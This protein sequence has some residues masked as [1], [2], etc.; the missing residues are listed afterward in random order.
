MEESERLFKE[1]FEV[2]QQDLIELFEAVDLHKEEDSREGLDDFGIE[3]E[4]KEPL[5]PGASSD[6]EENEN[7]NNLL[8]DF[9]IEKQ[10][11]EE[12]KHRAPVQSSS[13]NVYDIR[14]GSV[15]YGLPCI[16]QTRRTLDISL[17]NKQIQ[18]INEKLCRVM[19]H[20]SDYVKLE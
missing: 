9:A 10:A 17:R 5:A 2:N 4:L 13:V 7:L 19:R 1:I 11:K 12:Q 8:V 20:P 18:K 15:P 6:G 3:E 16:A 14:F